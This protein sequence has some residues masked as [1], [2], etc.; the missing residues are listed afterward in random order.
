MFVLVLNSPI[1]AGKTTT[2][3]A[4]AALLADALF[5]DGDDHNAPDDAPLLERIAA[6]FDRIECLIVTASTTVLVIAVPLRDED[7]ARLRA[8]CVLRSAELRV[9]TLAPPMDVALSDRGS[10]RLRPDEIDRSRQMYAE[11]YA[12]R[13]FS[14]LMI[15]EM[16]T[17]ELTARQIAR[18]FGLTTQL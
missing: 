10:R 14:D 8:A 4:I 3:Q 16:A 18:Y 13:S 7:I 2:G 1:N 6:S 11:G 12:S 17:P 9:V 5:V 15:S